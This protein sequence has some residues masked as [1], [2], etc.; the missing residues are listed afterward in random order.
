MKKI[1]IFGRGGQ[2]KV[3]LDCIKLIKT[4]K[5]IGF[6]SDKKYDPSFS[7]QIKY[8]GSIQDLNKIIKR[9]NSKNLYGVIAIGD[10]L[11]RKKILLK[12]KKIDKSFKWTNVIHPSAIISP[13]TIIGL[14]NMIL[15]GSVIS[16]ETKIYNH[17]SINTG[18]Y[19]DHN[20]IFHNFSSTG[21]G[22]ITGGNVTVS[23][24]SFLGI[25]SVIKDKIFI[26]K[27]TV[28][29]GKAFVRKNCKANSVYY[30]VPA[31]RIKKRNL[32]EPY[33]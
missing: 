30:G 28:I 18:S 24:Q 17:V 4:Y 21:P 12:I 1:I 26:G 22:V 25:G 31:K 10:N 7:R 20:N 9:Y 32:N 3:V 19:I 6:I 33:L 8:L 27:N 14:G 29:G 11:K 5:A 13:S 23:E 2:A 16:T 15:A